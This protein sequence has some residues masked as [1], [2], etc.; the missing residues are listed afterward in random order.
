[1]NTVPGLRLGA[2]TLCLVCNSFLIHLLTHGCPLMG[3]V[4]DKGGVVV[5]VTLLTTAADGPLV[6]GIGLN[7]NYD[8]D[9]P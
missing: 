7:C 3:V 8:S 2:V 5:V 4:S 6:D 9:D 1:M